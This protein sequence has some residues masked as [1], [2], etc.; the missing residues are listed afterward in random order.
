[1]DICGTTPERFTFCQNIFPYPESDSTPSWIL[2]PPESLTP[3]TGI[4]FSP[5]NFIRSHIFLAWLE[6]KDPPATVKS[7]LNAATCLP[8]TVP[9][10]HTMPSVGSTFF[11]MPKL[12]Q[13]C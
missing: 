6:P 11:S 8:L 3:I 1:M 13:L 10:P 9:I 2:A 12:W 4:P 7:W 5:A